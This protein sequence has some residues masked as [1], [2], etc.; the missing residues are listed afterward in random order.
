MRH[1]IWRKK[2]NRLYGRYNKKIYWWLCSCFFFG[3]PCNVLYL[4]LN[5]SWHL[6]FALRDCVVIVA[7]FLIWLISV[8]T[9]ISI[10]FRLVY[11]FLRPKVWFAPI[12]SRTRCELRFVMCSVCVGFDFFCCW[13]LGGG[14][15]LPFP[16]SVFPLSLILHVIA[17]IKR[18]ETI[19][20]QAVAACDFMAGRTVQ[21]R[22]V[23]A[24]AA[25]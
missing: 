7:L 20:S 2:S 6:T 13:K 18:V 15:S 19:A 14:A 17:W 12:P 3:P 24:W 10:N 8:T 21:S 16:S 23:R 25:A 1:V 5:W 11:D 22:R 4:R 9:V